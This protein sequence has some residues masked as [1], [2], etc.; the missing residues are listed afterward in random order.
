MK[1]QNLK[2]R[3]IKKLIAW[4]NNPNDVQKMVN[5]YFDYASK[6][7]LTVKSISECI[8]TIY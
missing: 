1:T 6:Q 3:V 2:Q 4:G 7:Y 8:R 5:Q